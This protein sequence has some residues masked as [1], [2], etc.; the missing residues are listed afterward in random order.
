MIAIIDNGERWSGHAIW[1]VEVESGDEAREFLRVVAAL[2]PYW[3]DAKILATAATVTWWRG[4]SVTIDA[5]I[6]SEA[7][8]LIEPDEEDFPRYDGLSLAWLERIERATAEAWGAG[9]GDFRGY[10]ARRRRAA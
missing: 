10:V 8:G 2:K 9:G 1:F 5:W 4:S 7:W 3:E 6:A